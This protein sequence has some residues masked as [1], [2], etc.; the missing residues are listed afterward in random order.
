[1]FPHYRNERHKSNETEV[2]FYHVK[3]DSH[4]DPLRLWRCRQQLKWSSLYSLYSLHT[5]LTLMWLFYLTLTFVSST[6]K[7]IQK[8]K[9]TVIQAQT[10]ACRKH[11]CTVYLHTKY[12]YI[13]TKKHTHLYPSTIQSTICTVAAHYTSCKMACGWLITLLAS[14]QHWIKVLNLNSANKSEWHMRDSL[15]PLYSVDRHQTD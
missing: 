9:A 8:D 12:T 2:V 5:Q 1:M 14:W 4:K 10:N 3:G 6:N 11:T 13:Y 7:Y 15:E